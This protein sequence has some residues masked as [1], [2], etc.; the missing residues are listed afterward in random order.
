MGNC[1]KCKKKSQEPI[2]S[3]S[4]ETVSFNDVKQAHEYLS[5]MSQM[6]DEKWD[7][8][9][10]VYRQLF[11]SSQVVNRGCADCLR[12]ISKVIT[13]EYNRMSELPENK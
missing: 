2:T 7:F 8:V 3:L 4:T 11:P 12:R 10:D 6:N 1:H 5:I 13:H 9:I